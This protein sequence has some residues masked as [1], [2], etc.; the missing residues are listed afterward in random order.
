MVLMTSC[1]GRLCAVRLQSRH[2]RSAGLAVVG[3]IV[4]GGCSEHQTYGGF[5]TRERCVQGKIA[6]EKGQTTPANLAKTC[7]VSRSTAS[8]SLDSWSV[9]HGGDDDS[10]LVDDNNAGTWTFTD[11]TGVTHSVVDDADTAFVDGKPEP[12]AFVA[13]MSDCD[14]VRHEA[15]FWDVQKGRTDYSIQYRAN[16]AAYAA[17]GTDRLHQLGC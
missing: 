5:K 14:A 6:A 9:N 15:Q 12:V 3:L 1:G 2:A 4:L 7:G 17:F 10:G 11:S 8:K 13:A 16:A